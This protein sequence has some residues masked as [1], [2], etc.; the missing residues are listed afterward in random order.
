MEANILINQILSNII[1]LNFEDKIFIVEKN[2]E[3]DKINN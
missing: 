1:K 2:P 3:N